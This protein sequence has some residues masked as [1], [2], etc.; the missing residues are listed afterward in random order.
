MLL[1]D[2]INT[3]INKKN[4][5]TP[6]KPS[7]QTGAFAKGTYSTVKNDAGDPHMIK[8]SFKNPTKNIE[9]HDPYWLYIKKI[10]DLILR[11]VSN[12]GEQNYIGKYYGRKFK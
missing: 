6:L 5:N 12:A 3:K 9:E 7:D 2:L 10:I 4:T 8:K 1:E 11:L